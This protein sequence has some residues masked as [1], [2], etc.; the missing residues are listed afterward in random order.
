MGSGVSLLE[1][2]ISGI[3]PSKLKDLSPYFKYFGGA[4]SAISMGITVNDYING[5]IS[6]PKLIYELVKL[7]LPLV[8]P[9]AAILSIAIPA[10]EDMGILLKDSFIEVYWGVDKYVKDYTITRGFVY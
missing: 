1:E 7:A 2:Y 4:L 8:S 3:S 6:T 5:K 10:I 9:E